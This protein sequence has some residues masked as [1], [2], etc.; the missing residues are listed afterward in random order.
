VVRIRGWFNI[1]RAAYP[2]ATELRYRHVLQAYFA[3]SGLNA[4]VPA[5]GG[6]VMKLYLAK[7][8][9]PDANYA[10]LAATL[11]VETLFD[12]VAASALLLWAL[13]LGVL[14][15]LH[16]LPDLPS[17]DWTWALRHPRL[18]AVV[19]GILA[20]GLAIAFVWLRRRV[21]EFRRRVARGFAIFRPPRRYVL[22][23]A[24]WQAASWVLRIA[25][26][27]WFL[28]AF[29]LPATVHNALLVQVVQSLSTLLPLTPGG[30]GTEQGLLVAVFHRKLP[31]TALL[32]FSV[33]Q[34]IAFSIVNV[35]LGFGAIFAMVR[36][37]DW[38]RLAAQ[39]ET[40]RAEES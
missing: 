28:R 1:L 17:V 25:S 33:G 30:F 34:K 23:V 19:A 18:A 32:S 4:V 24:T 20:V 36:T 37:L 2:R 16:V 6:D 31:A 22:R 26:V 21:D 15:G 38:R 3:G 13:T 14:P 40:P 8:A 39:R 12:S 11:V 27:W 10:T 9:V 5:R 35:V 29:D 7:R